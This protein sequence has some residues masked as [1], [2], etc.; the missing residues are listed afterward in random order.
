M[1]HLC[2]FEDATVHHLAPLASTRAAGDLRVGIQTLSERQRRA[3]PHDG[4]VLHTRALVAGAA[5]QDHAGASFNA[6]PNEHRGVLFVNQRWLVQP[7]DLLE[8]VRAAAAPGEPARVFLQGDTLL[9]AWHPAPQAGL[10]GADALGPSHFEGTAEEQVDGATLISRLWHLL[11]DVRERI[12]DDFAALDRHGRE[13]ATVHESAILLEPGNIY[14]APG[15]EVR[16]G[17]ILNAEGGPIYLDEGAAIG[18]GAIVFGPLYLGPNASMRAGARVDGVAAGT[19]AEIGGEVKASIVQS[20]S[21]KV[22][23]GYMGNSYIGRWC[24]LGADTNTSNLKNDYGEV[25]MWDCV[26]EAFVGTERGRLGLIMGDHSKCSINTMFNTGTVVGVFCNLFGGGFPP[27]YIPDFSWGGADGFVNY[28][29]EKALR[30][31]EAVTARRGMP[32]TD[33][34]RTL[35]TVI[36]EAAYARRKGQAA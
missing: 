19:H 11:D 33:T 6:L 26:A 13:G 24:N 34:D 5:A 9:A 31:A 14:L 25:N 32:L 2:L 12:A 4:F 23:D 22:H 16:P 10:L 28:R 30:V 35:L 36:A 15:A 17:A 1:P 8:R 21:N 20:Y 7:G 27:R 29:L 3:F 18:E